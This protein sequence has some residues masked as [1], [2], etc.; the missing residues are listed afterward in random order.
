[1]HFPGGA[2]ALRRLLLCCHS[3]GLFVLATQRVDHAYVVRRERLGWT[4]STIALRALLVPLRSLAVILAKADV[5][6]STAIGA[7][8][9]LADR[10]ELMIGAGSIGSGTLIHDRVT[11]GV[12]ASGEGPPVVGRDVWIGPD[13]V[14]YGNVRIGD[15]AT[16]LPGTVIATSVADREVVAGNPATVLRRN[17]DNRA[18]RSSLSPDV[19]RVSLA[20]Q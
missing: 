14:I 3:R 6:A 4:P 13:C 2:S 15:G 20:A 12:S 10:G 1:L 8:V 5:A 17:F 19:D 7:G 11:I 16:V 9:Y 18:L